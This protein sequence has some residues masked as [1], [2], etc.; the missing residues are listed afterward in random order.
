MSVL[1]N[2]IGTNTSKKESMTTYTQEHIIQLAQQCWPSDRRMW[3]VDANLLG[4]LRFVELVVPITHPDSQDAARYRWLLSVM[5]SPNSMG[6]VEKAFAHLD[7]EAN[8]TE[9]QFG[10]AVDAAIEGGE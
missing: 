4:L 9:Q 3:A 7:G 6:R 1:G 10:D 8:P 2:V 5:L